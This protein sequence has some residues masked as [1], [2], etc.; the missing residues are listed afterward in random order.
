MFK[1][2]T[3]A[4][5]IV[6]ALFTSACGGGG[7]SS[8]VRPS[9]G[10]GDLVDGRVSVYFENPIVVG[11]YQPLSDN[12]VGIPISEVYARDLNNNGV[13]EVVIAG[14]KS[15]PSSIAEWQDFNMQIYG[16]NTG[17]F[18]S[19]TDIWFDHSDNVILGT[20]PSVQ[21]AD[22]NSS[23]Y[24]DL[25]IAPST[26]MEHYGPA[27][28]FTNDGSRFVRHEID[29]G[30]AWSHGSAVAD[31]DGDGISDFLV[32]SRTNGWTVIVGSK[33]NEFEVIGSNQG[34]WA[35][36]FAA[37]DFLNDGSITVIA[38][39]A[40]STGNSD[41]KLYSYQ[42]LTDADGVR[43]LEFEEIA[44]LPPSRFYLD[45]W[46]EQ[47]NKSRWEPHEIRALPFDFN[48]D[49]LVDVLIFST[50]PNHDADSCCH[51]YSEVQFL[52]NLGNGEFVDV[53]DEILVGYDTK[54][55]ATYNPVLLDFNNNGLLDI[56]LSGNDGIY[57]PSNTTTVLIQTKD[58]FFVEQHTEVFTEFSTYITNIDEW[59]SGQPIAVLQGPNGV[60]YLLTQTQN[61]FENKMRVYLAEIGQRGTMT[62]A[63]SIATLQN[64]WPW[65]DAQAADNLLAMTAN[66]SFTGYDPTSHGEGI[67]DLQK[68]MQPIGWLGLS[69]SGNPDDREV[70]R[71]HFAAPGL[72]AQL[73]ER[74]AA[75]DD[76]GRD[77]WIN[78]SPLA[79]APL[80]LSRVQQVSM[81]RH[82]WT[83]NLMSEPVEWSSGLN[84]YGDN[85]NW[86]MGLQSEPMNRH[87]PLQLSF[88]F[89]KTLGSPWLRADGVFGRINE[90]QIF[91]VGATQFFTP[92]LWLHAGLMRTITDFDAGLITQITP[93]DSIHGAIGYSTGEWSVFAGIQPYIVS[94][95]VGLA[96]PTGKGADGNMQTQNHT[97]RLSNSAVQFAGLSFQKN[98]FKNEY[99]FNFAANTIGDQQA[100]LS[101]RRW[102][103]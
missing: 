60:N 69:H 70:I 1:T 55:M 12:A 75:V 21:F 40:P 43:Q 80:G 72:D 100:Q 54:R 24:L 13:D 15:Q 52:Q 2:K 96:L 30:N 79:S 89:A 94:G 85:R 20:E 44:V 32:R 41:T 51:G 10:G 65:L 93:I 37:A 66:K 73:F 29:V 83:L 16:W 86:T 78:L 59:N 25:L 48:N 22:V 102:F 11:T 57:R 53:T 8:N 99:A 84:M 64:I 45:K 98:V 74:V 26:D 62:A 9:T 92:N 35:S 46:T 31:F 34:A 76:F 38:T 36:D 28:V 90:S 58:G 95:S 17:S 47:R 18:T 81:S 3:I 71:G 42:L 7:G 50:L 67:I 27:L 4:I 82:I 14:R 87:F 91:E 63:A 68:A 77:Y 23:G 39:D 101:Y 56:M 49:G 5:A 19:E 61:Q 6:V 33:L 103:R 97:V 88:A